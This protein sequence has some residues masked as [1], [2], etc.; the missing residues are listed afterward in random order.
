MNIQTIKSTAIAAVAAVSIASFATVASTQSANAGSKF[1]KGAAAV[2]VGAIVVGG[3][4][5]NN[6][7]NNH[8]HGYNSNWN[9]HVNWCYDHRPRYR[10]SDNSFRRNGQHRRECFSPYYN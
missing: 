2:A 7:R 5:H 9:A 6:R 8:N 10:A 4:I 1:W 3:I